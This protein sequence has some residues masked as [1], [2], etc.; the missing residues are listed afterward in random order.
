MP[1]SAGKAARQA[2]RDAQDRGN[3]FLRLCHRFAGWS[4]ACSLLLSG[5]VLLT[6]A[7]ALPA[8]HETQ[9]YA[10]LSFVFSTCTLVAGPL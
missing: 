10:G 7:H 6:S 5:R 4:T 2:G 8:F 3:A 9:W 1:L